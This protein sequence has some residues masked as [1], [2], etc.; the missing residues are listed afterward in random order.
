MRQFVTGHTLKSIGENMV[1]IEKR[2][3]EV[4]DLRKHTPEQ[5]AELQALLDAGVVGRADLR[6]PD[7]Y[8]VDGAEDIYYVF[9]YPSGHKVLLIAAWKRHSP[10][11]G[12]GT[13]AFLGH[14]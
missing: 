5:I 8:E 9:R 2:S 4:E 14:R 13:K 12:D 1:A 7:F 3:L 6:R 11:E 10:P